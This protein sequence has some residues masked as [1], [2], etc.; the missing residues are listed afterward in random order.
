VLKGRFYTEL[1]LVGTLFN[2]AASNIAYNE[3][4]KGS[5]HVLFQGLFR[6]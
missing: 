6:Y 5:G 3:R 2:D 4:V 1:S